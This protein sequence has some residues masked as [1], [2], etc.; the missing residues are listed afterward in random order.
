MSWA[1][2]KLI[3][4]ENTSVPESKERFVRRTMKATPVKR[5]KQEDHHLL[6]IRSIL[7]DIRPLAG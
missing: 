6:M 3:L 4:R 7:A 2:I 1:A 5:R